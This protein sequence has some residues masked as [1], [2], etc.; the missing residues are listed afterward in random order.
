MAA[1]AALNPGME[2]AEGEMEVD[3][4]NDLN[5]LAELGIGAGARWRGGQTIVLAGSK[6]AG[7]GAPHAGTARTHARHRRSTQPFPR[8]LWQRISKRP[9]KVRAARG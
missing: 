3:D 1:E 4:F 7:K 5:R 6:L 8:P 2:V 9:R